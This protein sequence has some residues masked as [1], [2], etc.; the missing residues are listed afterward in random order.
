[1]EANVELAESS[2]NFDLVPDTVEDIDAFLDLLENPIYLSLK[3]TTCSHL[4]IR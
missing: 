3:L 4:R 2:V 1:M